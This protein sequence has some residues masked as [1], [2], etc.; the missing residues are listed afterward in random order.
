MRS[1]NTTAGTPPTSSLLTALQPD[2]PAVPP[3]PTD[4]ESNR[5]CAQ[6]LMDGDQARTI[7]QFMAALAASFV[8]PLLDGSCHWMASYAD[9]TNGDPPMRPRHAQRSLGVH[10]ASGVGPSRPP[11]ECGKTLT[12]IETGPVRQAGVS[13]SWRDPLAAGPAVD[14]LGAV[15]GQ[16]QKMRSSTVFWGERRKKRSLAN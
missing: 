16:S 12:W 11:P 1:V 9:L 8:E 7:N 5:S 10:R 15:D 13:D 2:L 6:D 14:V 4:G 3:R